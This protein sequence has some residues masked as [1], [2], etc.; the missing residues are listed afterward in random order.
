[1]LPE[2][3]VELLLAEEADFSIA[4]SSHHDPDLHGK[5]DGR[6][7]GTYRERRFQD[8]LRPRYVYHGGN[9]ARGS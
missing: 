3:T 9:A 8:R 6:A 1:M 7:I 2:L 5:T 4:Q